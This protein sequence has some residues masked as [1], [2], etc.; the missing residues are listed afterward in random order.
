MCPIFGGVSAGTDISDADAVVAD[1]KAPDTFYAVSGAKKTGTMPVSSY[2]LVVVPTTSQ[3]QIAAGYHSGAGNDALAGDANLVTGN[4]K[5]GV[6]IFAVIGKT[7]VVDT[8]EANP[9]ARGDMISG[10]KA[11]AGGSEIS[12]TMPTV[13]IVSGSN[14]YPAGYHAGDGAGLSHI[15]ASLAAANIKSGVNILGIAG[16]LTPMPPVASATAAMFDAFVA[17]GTFYSNPKNINDGD[18]GTYGAA[19][20]IGEYAQVAYGQLVKISRWRQW[21]E[22]SNNGDGSWKIQY[23]DLPTQ[24]W[25]DWVTGIATR[26][27]A[28]WSDYA[29]ATEVITTAIKLVCTAVDSATESFIHELE[30]IE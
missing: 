2:A 10:K 11:F 26:K 25:V 17:K 3:Q 5:A 4:I 19:A 7:E 12:G 16:S 1:V 27:A 28:S 18:T 29:S 24:A 22:G 9:P 30:V 21:G 20:T 6:T 14:A 8:T 15:E 23:W 13:A